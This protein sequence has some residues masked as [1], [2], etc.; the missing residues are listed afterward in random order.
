MAKKNRM[1]MTVNYRQKPKFL[2]A[3]RV[4]FAAGKTRA[5]MYEY[6][7]DH[8]LEDYAKYLG[9]SVAKALDECRS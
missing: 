6:F 2:R 7:I 5:E 9:E 8:H 1:S 3:D 4:A